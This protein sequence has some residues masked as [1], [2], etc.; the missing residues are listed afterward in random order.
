[1]RS[2]VVNEDTC[3]PA[4]TPAGTPFD[5]A[6]PAVASAFT[7]ALQSLLASLG[8]TT[9]GDIQVFC[10]D[11]AQGTVKLITVVATT[12]P[13]DATKAANLVA[14]L[15]QSGLQSF[16][17]AVTNN[18]Q[19]IGARFARAAGRLLLGI[20]S[21]APTA[22]FTDPTFG[23]NLTINTGGTTDGRWAVAAGRIPGGAS[24]HL[25]CHAMQQ[26]PTITGLMLA[27]GMHIVLGRQRT[28]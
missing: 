28:L 15:Q 20:T 7:R 3:L 18:L 4:G 22:N 19:Q 2:A 24:L 26:D 13:M 12:V 14:Q 10:T 8:T 23:L 17:T 9:Q 6:R 11:P 27:C 21:W 1:M 25:S 5:E 16:I